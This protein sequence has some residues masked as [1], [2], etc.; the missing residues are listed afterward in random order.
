MSNDKP[1]ATL[2]ATCWGCNKGITMPYSDFN[3][4]LS[5]LEN[6]L[7]EGWV[8]RSFG[9]NAWVW[10]CSHD[11]AYLSSHAQQA[12]QWWKDHKPAIFPWIIVLP[13]IALIA[14]FVLAVFH[15]FM[16]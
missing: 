16:R 3:N 11:C 1:T 15:I 14:C 9:P 6:L 10:F 13:S 8:K 5:Q 7:T 4:S 12:E 2:T